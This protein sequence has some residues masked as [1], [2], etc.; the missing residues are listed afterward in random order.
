MEA[1]WECPWTEMCADD[2]MIC[3]WEQPEGGWSSEERACGQ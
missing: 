3:K 1:R 2:I